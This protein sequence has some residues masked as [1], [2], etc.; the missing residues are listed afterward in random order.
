M[1]GFDTNLTDG[2]HT[3]LAPEAG[4]V[5]N[6][7]VFDPQGGLYMSDFRGTSTLALGGVYYFPP[8]LDTMAPVLPGLCM[9]N[10]VALSPDGKVLWSTE[11][12]AGRLHRA[13]LRAPGALAQS[14]SSAVRCPTT[15]SVL[16]RTRCAQT[17]RAMSM[18]Q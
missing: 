1:A 18:W 3:I 10:G 15:L 12:G 6:D 14:G 11:F 13:E 5:P 9:A 17:A 2:P 7:L 8:A 16:G 4:Y